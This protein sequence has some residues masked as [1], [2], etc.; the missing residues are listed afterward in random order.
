VLRSERL[1]RDFQV[2]ASSMEAHCAQ[3]A[4]PVCLYTGTLDVC[5]VTRNAAWGRHP[6][7]VPL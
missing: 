7:R 3:K 2:A 6:A 5:A 4:A 1:C